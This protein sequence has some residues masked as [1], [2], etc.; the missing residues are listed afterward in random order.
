M[1]RQRMSRNRKSPFSKSD[2]YI[3][4]ECDDGETPMEKLAMSEEYAMTHIVDQHGELYRCPDDAAQVFD[5]IMNAFEDYEGYD[6]A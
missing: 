1:E 2:R 6:N 4:S 5:Q 3:C